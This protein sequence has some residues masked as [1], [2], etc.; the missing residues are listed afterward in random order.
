[1]NCLG[2]PLEKAVEVPLVALQTTSQHE[3]ETI[4]KSLE[5]FKAPV[6]V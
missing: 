1:M 5:V 3:N 4:R 6:R 2:T